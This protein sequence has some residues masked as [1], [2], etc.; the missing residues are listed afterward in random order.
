MLLHGV[1]DA[2]G[3]KGLESKNAS[4]LFVMEGRPSLHAAH[5]NI[6]A[7][8][9]LGKKP[10]VICDNMAGFL[11][12]KDLINEVRLACQFADDNGALCDTG[13][14]ILGVLARWHKV[15]VTVVPGKCKPRFLGDPKDTLTFQKKTV[16]PQ[17]TQSYAPLLEWLPRKYITGH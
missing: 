5:D 9:K 10:T 14:L 17:G 7:L 4:A 15:P 2:A 12:Y 16:A 6:R 1:F 11:F 13:A 8:I 3:L